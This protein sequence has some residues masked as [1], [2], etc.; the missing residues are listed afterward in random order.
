M[1]WIMLI[2]LVKCVGCSSCAASAAGTFF[3]S[4]YL[5]GR[6]LTSETGVYP[7]VKS[8]YIPYCASLRRAKMC[9]RLPHRASQQRKDGIIWVDTDKCVGCRY[10]VMA[11]PYQ[12]RTYYSEEKECYPGQGLTEFRKWGRSCILINRNS[13]KCNF[14]RKG[15]TAVLSAAESWC[16]P[17]CDAA[18]VIT[19]PPKQ[20]TSV[21]WMTRIARF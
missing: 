17:G 6:L 18:C 3:T 20:G 13:V 8:T 4:Q 11:C 9:R 16:G 15:S 10:C 19:C 7:H 21:I 1:R 5:M 14:C 2:N 12:V